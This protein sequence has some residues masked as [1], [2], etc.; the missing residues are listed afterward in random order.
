[1]AFK[2]RNLK[3]E[4]RNFEFGFGTAKNTNSM[5]TPFLLVV[6]VNKKEKWRFLS[7]VVGP[8]KKP[9][10]ANQ[11]EMNKVIQLLLRNPESTAVER[12]HVLFSFVSSVG[13]PLVSFCF[14]AP[15][16]CACL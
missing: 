14:A 11:R 1:M 12:R 16:H 6:H 8:G 9:G 2:V 13:V 10:R 5:E 7:N 3:F 15:R 4:A